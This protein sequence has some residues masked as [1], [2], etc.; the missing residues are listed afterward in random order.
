MDNGGHAPLL[1]Q[2]MEAVVA[3]L[4]QRQRSLA[5]AASGFFAATP[6][7]FSKHSKWLLSV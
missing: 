3:G 2:R 7:V 4:N 1:L 6:Q 5:P